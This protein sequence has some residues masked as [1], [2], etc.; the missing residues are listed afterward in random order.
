MFYY[1]GKSLN[2]H[3]FSDSIYLIEM[4]SLMNIDTVFKFDGGIEHGATCANF[5]Q[6]LLWTTSLNSSTIDEVKFYLFNTIT[7]KSKKIDIGKRFFSNDNYR[8]IYNYHSSLKNH[9][10]LPYFNTDYENSFVL[11]LD[12]NLQIIDTIASLKN[13]L[14]NYDV[15]NGE[16]NSLFMKSEIDKKSP[17]LVNFKYNF[18]LERALYRITKNKLIKKEILEKLSDVDRM[19]LLASIISKEKGNSFKLKQ[20]EAFLNLHY[21]FNKRYNK[22]IGTYQLTENDHRNMELLQK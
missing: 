14:V 11:T 10:I 19:I 16:I 7:R 2:K 15:V 5:S 18:N 21:F 20:I 12:S 6:I 9:F 13:H 4:D 22:K 3:Y 17:V 1:I 8:F